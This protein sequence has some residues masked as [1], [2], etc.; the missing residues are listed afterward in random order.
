MV[1]PVLIMSTM[2][3]KLQCFFS[4]LNRSENIRMKTML[5]DLVIVYSATSMYSKLH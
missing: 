3:I 4:N 1:R 5:V 2:M